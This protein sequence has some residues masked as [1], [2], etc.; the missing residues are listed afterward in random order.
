MRGTD[1]AVPDLA[2]LFSA[3]QCRLAHSLE[4]VFTVL[5]ILTSKKKEVLSLLFFVRGLSNDDNQKRSSR[6]G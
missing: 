1:G 4:P 2:D 5:P 3:C 6:H